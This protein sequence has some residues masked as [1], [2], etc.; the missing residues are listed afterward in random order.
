M[1]IIVIILVV[2]VMT[3]DFIRIKKENWRMSA[4]YLSLAAMSALVYLLNK[5]EVFN[6]SPMEMFIKKMEPLTM[7]VESMLK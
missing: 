3:M 6:R 2:A 4:V 1:F 5:L 7:W